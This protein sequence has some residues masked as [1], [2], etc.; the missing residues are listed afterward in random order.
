MS[1]DKSQNMDLSA[2]SQ[3]G[4]APYEHCLNCGAELMGGY[5]HQ[6]GQR[7]SGPVPK[8][9]EFIAEYLN[10]AYIWDPLFFPTLWKLI[11]RPGFLTREFMSGKFITYENPLKLN[12]F[13][14][15]VFLS[16]FVIFTDVDQLQ[17]EYS[18]LVT[19]EDVTAY[20]V[21]KALYEKEGY[22]EQIAQSE[23]DTVLVSLPLG[24]ANEFPQ[25]ITPIG[26]EYDSEKSMPATYLA[27]VPTV[28]FEDGHLVGDDVSGY[29]FP[30][31]NELVTEASMQLVIAKKV[32]D[33]LAT[34]F[35]T[36]FPIIVLLTVPLLAM[37]VGIIHRRQKLPKMNFL[38]FSLHYVA[39]LE[40]LMLIIYLLYVTVNPSTEALE[41]I[42]IIASSIYLVVAVKNVYG[43]K[44]WFVN[45]IKAFMINA[46]Y[47]CIVLGLL[48][49][50]LVISSIIVVFDAE[51]LTVMS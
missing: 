34:L 11:S 26:V 35:S 31:E 41:W 21:A 40:L 45:I 33:K 50:I 13:F 48:L 12:M 36:Y 43:N 23:R 49:G 37:A 3:S 17:H 29:A 39:F 22:A 7:A 9:G 25:M 28:L 8:I 6:C 27:S 46:I 1:T 16:I 14:M 4:V 51:I 24:V 10:N 20:I 38:I 15:F 30:N 32:W 19:R 47:M 42:M 2:T 5:C 44:N 18:E